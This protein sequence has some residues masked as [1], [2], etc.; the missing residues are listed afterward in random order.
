[1]PIL[2]TPSMIEPFVSRFEGLEVDHLVELGIRRGGSTAL[3]HELMR[4]ERL[5]AFELD[6][7]PTPA[8]TDYIEAR[9][10]QASIRP[11]YGVDQADRATV[12]EV[13]DRELRGRP[14]D[15]VIDDASHRYD[16]TLA[17]FEVLF[18]RLRPG[19]LFIIED[20]TANSYNLDSLADALAAASADDRARLEAAIASGDTPEPARLLP[21]LTL[22][23]VLMRA[24]YADVVADVHVDR[25][26]TTVTRGSA[27]LDP[28]TFRVRD[29][30]YDHMHLFDRLL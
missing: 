24:T 9:S 25:Y 3:L 14:I 30:H 4:P 28:D 20:W 6:P 8:L 15:L 23:L 29:H 19:G 27:P 13:V 2:K 11:H 16:P 10:L 22:Q 18:P 21:L 1:M 5:V 12:A 7:E 26:W 17:S